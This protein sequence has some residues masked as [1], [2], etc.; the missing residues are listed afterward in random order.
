MCQQ[1]GCQQKNMDIEVSASAKKLA[2]QFKL[3]PEELAFADLVA[4]GWS[5]ED[6]WAVAVRKGVTWTKAARKEAVAQLAESTAVKERI[7]TV[8][9]VLKKSQIEAVKNLKDSERQVLIS[10]ATSKE[11]ML[12]DLQEALS[13]MTRG[14]KEWLDTKK[15]IIDVTRMKQDEVKDENNT[16]H[17][18]LPI[19]Y[20]MSCEFC[21][22]NPK[23]K[24]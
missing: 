2:K 23:N 11:Q 13:T 4:V 16:I 15:L 14:S 24:K 20:P 3:S 10:A 17:Y 1:R 6:A 22:R 7:D 19:D 18:Y 21:L 12:F 8:K 9:A 5:Q